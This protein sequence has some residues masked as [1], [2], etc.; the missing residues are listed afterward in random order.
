MP[1]T[2]NDLRA[3]IYLLPFV[4]TVKL[5]GKGSL[6]A[7]RSVVLN[8]DGFARFGENNIIVT[9]SPDDLTIWELSDKDINTFYDA[10]NIAGQPYNYVV[11]PLT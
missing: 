6:M 2:Q 7:T 4:T 9:I 1:L 8:N 10:T 5:N 3:F 11:L